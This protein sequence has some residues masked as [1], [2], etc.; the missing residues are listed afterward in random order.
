LDSCI[1]VEG[2]LL[3]ILHSEKQP[4]HLNTAIAQ[5]KSIT[6]A[7]TR[8]IPLALNLITVM[9]RTLFIWYFIALNGL[10]NELLNYIRYVVG[11]PAVL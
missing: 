5:N 8:C 11:H 4:H 2:I 1:K 10:Q 6:A 7:L 9:N 3:T